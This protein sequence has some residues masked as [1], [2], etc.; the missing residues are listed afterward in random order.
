MR[1][2]QQKPRALV[3]CKVVAGGM[4][5]ALAISHFTYNLVQH[6]WAHTDALLM[7]TA[8]SL[9]EI[10]SSPPGAGWGGK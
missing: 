6:L 4:L 10:T 1:E 2:A 7:G 8:P 3:R 5:Q 9:K